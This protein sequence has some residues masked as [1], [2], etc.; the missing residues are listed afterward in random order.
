MRFAYA[1]R[2]VPLPSIQPTAITDELNASSSSLILPMTGIADAVQEGIDW[3]NMP[4]YLIG[5]AVAMV[6]GILSI[7]LLKYIAGKGKFSGFAYY[8]WVVGVLSIILT[9]IF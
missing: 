9:M 5:M 6:S 4:A 3:S 7:S 2:A 1:F 8:C